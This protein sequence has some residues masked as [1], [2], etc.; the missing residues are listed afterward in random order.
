[1]GI[2]IGAVQGCVD[3]HSS[4][5]TNIVVTSL[6]AGDI[7]L[8]RMKAKRAKDEDES[9]QKIRKMWVAGDEVVLSYQPQ[10]GEAESTGTLAGAGGAKERDRRMNLRDRRRRS[11]Q[12]WWRSPSWNAID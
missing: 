4:R 8:I 3:W 10:M 7:R 2:E 12:G 1:M 9:R 6:P 5:G 11:G